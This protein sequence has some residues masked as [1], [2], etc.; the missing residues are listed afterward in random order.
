MYEMN[1]MP[2]QFNVHDLMCGFI[3]Q[4]LWFEAF[5]IPSMCESSI[6]RDWEITNQESLAASRRWRLQLTRYR[7]DF[8]VSEKF[9]LIA[10]I[11]LNNSRLNATDTEFHAR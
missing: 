9:L 6:M 3:C 10:S 2:D 5:I 4:Y 11:T 1:L 7:I 8:I